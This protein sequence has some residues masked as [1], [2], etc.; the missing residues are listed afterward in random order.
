[1]VGII[2]YGAYIPRK[3]LQ[4][5]VA[6]EANS[7][8]NPA[9]KA[10]S[11]G[12]RAMCNWDED[13]V[14]MA[15]EA[16]RD[17]FGTNTPDSLTGLFLA[18]TSAPFKDRQ[19]AGILATALNLGDNLMT[20]D[21]TA[22]QRAGTSGL[23]TALKLADG[24]G[25]LLFAASE[26]RRTK[27]ANP[28]ELLYGD[29]A[30]AF[31]VGNAAGAAEFLGAKQISVDFVDHYKGDGEDFDYYWEERWIRDEGYMKLVPRA[32]DGLF[33]ETG[34]A[35]DEV[36]HF[37]MPCVIRRV[38]SMVAKAAGIPAKAICDNMHNEMGEAGAAHALIM[39]AQSL[40]QAEPGEVIVIAGFGQGCDT[41]MFRTT[42][43]IEKRR[44]SMGV[45]GFLA[46]RVEESNYNKYLAFN[47]LMTLDHGLR[48][49]VDRQTAL[50]AL[51]RNKKM[52]TGFVGGKCRKCGTL[53]FPKTKVCVNPNCGEFHSQDDHP[54]AD[55]PA[56]VQ[57]WTAD[58]LTY[59]VEPPQHFGM[60]TF[61]EG[62]RLMSDLT[63]VDEGGVEVG[64]PMRMMFRVKEFDS[65]RGFTRYFW[66]AAPD[67]TKDGS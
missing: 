20:M 61:K 15:V 65:H 27:A 45:S 25:E 46:R 16:A 52:L 66:K 22:S 19:N 29:G 14:T 30:A 53:Q 33:S 4:R 42:G 48:G 39:L 36:D 58:N 21:V 5:S 9:L 10:Y 18:T 54:F 31:V 49:E 8:F 3:R 13:A 23:V 28:Q 6:V 40:E 37:I 17:C 67:F 59:A 2:S 62:G 38:G 32:L 43:E 1:M 47:D 34:V 12:E 24:G 7:W 60:V 50:T 57:S 55:M 35:P 64:M 41:L 56:T 11:K 26:K 63:D 44:P 51:Y